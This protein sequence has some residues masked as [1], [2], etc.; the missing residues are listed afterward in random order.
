[1]TIRSSSASRS[2]RPAVRAGLPMRSASRRSPATAAT[3]RKGG[4]KRRRG[5]AVRL[6]RRRDAQRSCQRR[7]RIPERAITHFPG[8]SGNDAIKIF[9]ETEPFFQLER[10]L[11]ADEARFDL[12]RCNDTY[13]INILSI[14]FDARVGT[15]IARFKRLP[16]VTGKG[17]MSSPSLP[18]CCM[19]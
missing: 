13:S 5:T 18:I 10:L 12:I 11:D 6:R 2:R 7:S 19:G 1:M 15:D 16:L 4:G 17:R 14:G 8:G 9:S 3:L